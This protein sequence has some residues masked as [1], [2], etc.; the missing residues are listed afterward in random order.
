MKY[1]VKLL[2]LMALKINEMLWQLY[3]SKNFT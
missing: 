3:I 2:G 1:Y